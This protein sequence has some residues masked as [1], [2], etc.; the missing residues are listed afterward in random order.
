MVWTALL[1]NLLFTVLPGDSLPAICSILEKD[2]IFI[3][4]K[5]MKFF[6][7]SLNW[8][9][10]QSFC[11]SHLY[12]SV[13][14]ELTSDQEL[15]AVD[16]LMQIVYKNSVWVGAYEMTRI[17]QYV[18]W[19]DNATVLSPPWGASQPSNQDGQQT[20]VE[21]INST[22]NARSCALV[23]PFV[24][25]IRIP[26]IIPEACLQESSDT[27][28]I[29]GKCVKVFTNIFL[30]WSN[31]QNFCRQTF[32][33]GT[34]VEPV[35]ELEMR[36]VK[37]LA[38]SL[39]YIEYTWIGA[40]DLIFEGSFVWTSDEMNASLTSYWDQAQPDNY[41]NQDCVA[42]WR[43]HNF[44]LDDWFCETAMSFMCQTGKHC[45]LDSVSAPPLDEK[46][47]CTT[48]GRKV[49]VHHL[50][51]KS[52]GAPPLVERV[53]ASPLVEMVDAAPLVERVD[54][55]P[56][57]ERVLAP[58]LVESVGAPPL[59]ERVDAS[60]LVERVLAPPLVERVLA[61]PLVERVLAPPLVKRVDAPPLVERVLAPP[62]VERVIAPPLVE[63]VDAAP[64][65]ER[66]LAPPLVERVDA[67]PLV[68]R[69]D[70]APLVERVLAP[71]LVER[72]LAP[73]L[74]ERVLAAPLV[75]RVL[76][77]PLVERVDAPPLVERVLAPP[78]V[79]RVLA[80]PLVERVLAPPLVERVLAPPL[81][82]RV[83]AAP[84]VERVLAPPQVER[85]DA[86]P[87]VE[88]VL[89]PPLVE[90][91]DAA[92]LVE[93]VDAAPLV[94]R[95]LAPPLVE[96]VGAPPLVERVDASPLV[97]RVLAP[98][99][100][101]RVLAPPL[102]ERVLAPPLVKRVDAP[103]LVERVDAPPL[104][105]RVLAPPL[106]ERVL[107]SPLV[108]RVL[109]PPLVKRVDAPPLVE[110]V[111]A[112]PLVERVL[113]PPLVERVLA[114][115]L[116]E[117]VIAPPLVERVD[118][119]PLV[120]RVLA[121]PLVERV[122][123]P[124]LVERVD[125]APLVERVLAP[126]LV[127]R[128]LAPPLV[129]RVLAPPLVERVLAA[130]LVERVLAP[131]Q[132]ERVDAA[133]LVERVLAPPLV[134][135]VDA[136]PLVERV[137]A[138][139]LVERV[140]AAPLDGKCWCTTSSGK[141][142]LNVYVDRCFPWRDADYSDGQCLKMFNLT[143][144]WTSA[145]ATCS[146]IHNTSLVEMLNENDRLRL[147]AY[148]RRLG[149]DQF[150]V[151]AQDTYTNRTFYWVTTPSVTIAP[152][153]W[154][155]S[156][157]LTGQRCV[158]IT[159]SLLLDYVSCTSE[160]YYI[161]DTAGL[162]GL[163]TRLIPSLVVANFNGSQAVCK[164]LGGSLAEVS[165]STILKTLSSPL[166]NNR[167]YYVG[168]NDFK[169]TG[170]F[171]W[172]RQQKIIPSNWWETNEPSVS[173]NYCVSMSSRSSL[174]TASDCNSSLPFVCKIALGNICSTY[175]PGAVY[176]FGQCYKYFDLQLSWSM[177]SLYCL[178]L[179][180]YLAE[181]ETA[182]M[183]TFLQ[184]YLQNRTGWIGANNLNIKSQFRWA[185]SNR[186]MYTGFTFLNDNTG[187]SNYVLWR[188]TTGAGVV[189]EA[190]TGQELNGFVC[191]TAPTALNSRFYVAV[192]PQ[193]YNGS[194]LQ[195]QLQVTS[196][197]AD[198]IYI[199][200]KVSYNKSSQNTTILPL[201]PRTAVNFLV[202]ENVFL[203]TPDIYDR[204]IE[205]NSSQPV[206][207]VQYLSNQSMVQASS[208]LVYPLDMYNTGASL[209][210]YL[211]TSNLLSKNAT[212]NHVTVTSTSSAKNEIQ[213]I[214][215]G[216]NTS[217]I[218]LVGNSPVNFCLFDK[219]NK[220]LDALYQSVLVKTSSN[221]D[222][223]YLYS[224]QPFIVHLS[225]P[226]Q[227]S[228]NQMTLDSTLD[229]LLPLQYIGR[230]YFIIQTENFQ[231]V[232]SIKCLAAYNWTSITIVSS[233]VKSVVLHSIGVTYET[234]LNTSLVSSYVYGNVS[235]YVYQTFSTL[236][237][238]QQ[239]VCVTSLLPSSLWRYEYDFARVSNVHTIY[240][241]IILETSLTSDIVTSYWRVNWKCQNISGT[242]YSGCSSLLPSN[243]T[244][245]HIQLKNKQ[246]TFGSYVL[247]QSSTASL[248]HPMGIAEINLSLTTQPLF[249]HQVYLQHLQAQK[250]SVCIKESSTLTSDITTWFTSAPTVNTSTEKA[251]TYSTS[252]A[253]LAGVTGDPINTSTKVLSECLCIS[254]TAAATTHRTVEEGIEA[255][256]KIVTELK[257]NPKNVSSYRR[258][259]T[260]A[261]DQRRS[262]EAFGAAG[263]IIIAVVIAV[264]VISDVTYLWQ[265]IHSFSHKD[266]ALAE[267]CSA[268]V[269]VSINTTCFKSMT[270][271]ESKESEMTQE[272]EDSKSSSNQ[273][274]CNLHFYTWTSSSP[275]REEERVNDRWKEGNRLSLCLTP[276]LP[277]SEWKSTYDVA[278]VSGSYSVY[279][280]IIIN[281]NLAS[282][283]LTNEISMWKWNCQNISGTVYSGCYTTLTKIPG[284]VNEIHL[285]HL[286]DSLITSCKGVTATPTIFSE[287]N[288]PRHV[289][290]V[291]NSTLST[292]V[293]KE[294]SS[295]T[296]NFTDMVTSALP[297]SSEK[298]TELNGY[299]VTG[300]YTVTQNFPEQNE[301]I[302]SHLKLDVHKLS[303]YK[304][305]LICATDTRLSANI[306]GGTIIAVASMVLFLIVLPDLV[307]VTQFV[308]KLIKKCSNE[309]K[310]KTMTSLD[311]T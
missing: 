199:R 187:S 193:L 80:P 4:N 96:S 153:Q 103:P 89:A 52:V 23:Q 192:M 251:T 220:S 149:I 58:P 294:V 93:R 307:N 85:V 197:N 181:P 213:L 227:V 107:A 108:E 258:T 43:S 190:R 25:Q 138:P 39:V 13:L 133:P 256:N 298:T 285:Q 228:L 19:S 271:M 90:R 32:Y 122:D 262:S 284:I 289:T 172:I 205:V 276:L 166:Q 209:T 113:A 180:S 158:A 282:R 176:G 304:R 270:S 77:P 245:L 308:V 55:A 255:A 2:T 191:Q 161:C 116:V 129:E 102:V 297:N 81:V 302:S 292:H 97:E 239:D 82:E 48:S 104:V 37:A 203:A 72:V 230:E 1:W 100:V 84:L 306:V 170:T 61:P 177:A 254:S 53:D 117:R 118:A 31:A 247:A 242:Q 286:T 174:L 301:P 244:Y 204:Y 15:Q 6:N 240:M 223:A 305:T 45:H 272:S 234:A 29:D 95:V 237:G 92:P 126:P 22:L 184:D 266:L 9:D 236:K 280:Y 296:I 263:V 135:R 128:V 212:D 232:S 71:P 127:E 144:N 148:S 14:A 179:N 154:A 278:S 279:I 67:P 88:R 41:G 50:W 120:E 218:L 83:L 238:S 134:E 145:Q 261:L 267:V 300:I 57:V 257:M 225:T 87:L 79:E 140:L 185:V 63:R 281:V 241:Y 186:T 142:Q 210:S 208:T 216:Q 293:S 159:A 221:L 235:F 136:A 264:F 131:P 268:P 26:D 35:N 196:S 217:E 56:L 277:R 12:D 214:F 24:C 291:L 109:A 233:V 188:Y 91:V 252:D 207:I 66:V 195:G 123:A 295:S 243:I 283:L 5:C 30:T 175:L 38:K 10:A 115:P 98:P 146:N 290:S 65:V 106:V 311:P 121:P 51:T 125:A 16:N 36:A 3:N 198:V 253:T 74:V 157:P 224:T 211:L 46:Y 42:L 69:V 194:S 7:L 132:V 139:P 33:N 173:A 47:W 119:A 151:G 269:Y 114:P 167:L 73:P 8:Q 124:P 62:L 94:E 44:N 163:N 249:Q 273:H 130:P 34:L 49:L 99:L 200:F 68:E 17:G 155:R 287:S 162:L 231:T 111:L 274:S 310:Q 164:G 219:L 288:A 226:E 150:W 143:T 76:A 78:L 70:A 40:N 171:E 275:T 169:S 229:E 160:L 222:G 168:A 141:S 309:C 156:G 265:F 75:E 152:N 259:L 18:W 101:E 189:W 86:A 59:V 28:F 20:C 60:P 178:K 182:Q 303:S 206:T 105:E 137:L 112:P 21:L 260:S 299:N 246:K 54:A 11:Q 110:R 202:D 250:N 183:Q 165:D 147:S 64:L 248:C 27:I 215:Q 201:A